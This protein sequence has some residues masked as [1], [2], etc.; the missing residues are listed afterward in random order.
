MPRAYRGLKGPNRSVDMKMTPGK[1]F[2]NFYWMEGPLEED[3]GCRITVLHSG[4][5]QQCSHCLRRGSCPARGNGKACLGL[6][7]LRGKISD[8]MRYLKETHNYLS[9]KM[10]YK[11]VMEKEFPALGRKKVEEDGFEHMVETADNDVENVEK[12][13]AESEAEVPILNVDPGDFIYDEISDSVSPKN[14]TEFDKMI[15]EH[16]S[17]NTL[18]RDDKREGKVA[19]LKKKI[20]DSLK[21]EER[22]RRD[23]S[24]ESISSDC[25]GWGQGEA[26]SDRDRSPGNR[27]EVRLRSDDEDNSTKPS[28][29]SRKSRTV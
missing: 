29:S 22:K 21:V 26:I 16:S 8:Y 11:M 24:C 7:T 12:N 6:N 20:L 14:T 17:V 13:L 5:E 23:L 25:S 15:E 19:N 27:G 1:Q 4:Q 9:L 18:K 10:K 3:R 2:E 28:K